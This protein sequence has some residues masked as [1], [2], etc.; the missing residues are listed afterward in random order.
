MYE[1]RNLSALIDFVSELPYRIFYTVYTLFDLW[2]TVFNQLTGYSDVGV[3]FMSSSWW[4]Q[5]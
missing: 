3:N 4:W 1:L 5:F 2:I